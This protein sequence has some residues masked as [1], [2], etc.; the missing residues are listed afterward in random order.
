MD[1]KGGRAWGSDHNAPMNIGSFPTEAGSLKLAT[2]FCVKRISANDSK[3]A[4]VD[5]AP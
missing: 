1:L 4:K 2:M 5:S 3:N